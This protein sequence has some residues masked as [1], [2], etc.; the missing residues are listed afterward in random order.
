[1]VKYVEIKLQQTIGLTP[2]GK[3]AFDLYKNLVQ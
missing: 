2:G 3:G 1:M